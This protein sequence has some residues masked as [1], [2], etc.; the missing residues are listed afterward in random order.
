MSVAKCHNFTGCLLAYRGEAI[1]LSAGAPLVCPEC[2]KPVTIVKPLPSKIWTVLVWLLILG[3]AA[4]GIWYERA[5]ISPYI[6]RYMHASGTP[7]HTPDPGGLHTRPRDIDP[8]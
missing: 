2:G 1:T 8:A 4:G 5:A 7:G 3:A 6:E